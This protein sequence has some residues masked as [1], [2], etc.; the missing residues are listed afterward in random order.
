MKFEKAIN[1]AKISSLIQQ[2]KKGVPMFDQSDDKI[3]S[4]IGAL[5][6]D[7]GNKITDLASAKNM[8]RKLGLNPDDPKLLKALTLSVQTSA[9][10]KASEE[11]YSAIT[12]ERALEK[13]KRKS[14][15][16][17]QIADRGFVH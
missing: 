12:R 10:E 2:Y 17:G 14:D 1:E 3:K 11:S 13:E 5:T 16:R 7:Q 8:V 15:L 9:Q 6:D 4:Y